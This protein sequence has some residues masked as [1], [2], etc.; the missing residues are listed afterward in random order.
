M[1]SAKK[2]ERGREYFSVLSDPGSSM[3]STQ[4]LK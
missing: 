4:M 2:E 1:K 3:L